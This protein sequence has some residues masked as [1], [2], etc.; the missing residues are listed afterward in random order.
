MHKGV[1]ALWSV[2]LPAYPAFKTNFGLSLHH[3][4]K[5]KGWSVGKAPSILKDHRGPANSHPFGKPQKLSPS[6]KRALSTPAKHRPLWWGGGDP[7]GQ[8]PICKI[9]PTV[10]SR[11]LFPCLVGWTHRGS[12][13]DF[14][15]L[16]HGGR[17][18]AASRQGGERKKKNP[19]G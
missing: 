3:H 4:P 17:A 16:P 2:L 8:I 18:E 14:F 5:G 10:L 12:V 11:S 13:W 19:L 9:N 7:Q 15:S 1:C 6:P